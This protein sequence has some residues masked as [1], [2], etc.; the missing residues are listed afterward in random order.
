MTT[1]KL[2][3]PVVTLN[4]LHSTQ[5]EVTGEIFVSDP[6]QVGNIISINLYKGTELVYTG[7]DLELEYKELDNNT[8]YTIVVE[9]EYDI[10][11]TY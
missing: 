9:Y 3:K 5:S 4:N 11:D 1:N 10:N 2:Y 6:S 8:R 7:T